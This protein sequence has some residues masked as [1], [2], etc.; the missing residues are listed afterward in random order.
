MNDL[1][2]R[3]AL[4]LGIEDETHYCYNRPCYSTDMNAAKELDAYAFEH[5]WQLQVNRMGEYWFADYYNPA[6]NEH[7]GEC[8]SEVEATA[9]TLAFLELHKSGKLGEKT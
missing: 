1:D 9:R 4:A 7:A 5:G 8:S 6:A 2:R 3:A